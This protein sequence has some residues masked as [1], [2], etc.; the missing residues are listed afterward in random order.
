MH[1]VKCV[2]TEISNF[3]TWTLKSGYFKLKELVMT[4][5][6][7]IREFCIQCVGS[8]HEVPSCG[9]DK[10]RNGE[11]KDDSKCWFFPYRM[12]RGR[13]SVKLI[14]KICL[15]CMGE[16]E[17]F[18]RECWTPDCPLHPYRMGFNPAR[19]GVGKGRNPLVR[20]EI[21]S[22]NPISYGGQGVSVPLQIG[23]TITPQ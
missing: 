13:P 18:V 17:K 15:S 9:G 1:K 6:Q 20:R 14:R 11:C 22:A 7:S 21:L 16:S 2:G 8:R 10:C 12:G 3:S 5:L 23:K 4:P 19:A